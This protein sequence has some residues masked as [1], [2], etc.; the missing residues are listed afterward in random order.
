MYTVLS[1]IKVTYFV[2]PATTYRQRGALHILRLQL[3]VRNA[4][5]S[6]PFARPDGLLL[7]EGR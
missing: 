4:Y 6:R 2:N 7:H 5:P 1:L 3:V